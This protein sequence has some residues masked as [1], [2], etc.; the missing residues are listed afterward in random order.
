MIKV[1]TENDS[2]IFDKGAGKAMLKYLLTACE[3][4]IVYDCLEANGFHKLS[5]LIPQAQLEE[6][7]ERVKTLPSTK[8]E[9]KPRKK[10]EDDILLKFDKAFESFNPDGYFQVSESFS[11]NPVILDHPQKIRA[12]ELQ[13][14]LDYLHQQIAEGL[15]G[16]KSN[17]TDIVWVKDL[18]SHGSKL[19]V[20]YLEYNGLKVHFASNTPEYVEKRPNQL[21]DEDLLLG[22]F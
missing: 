18:I 12:D 17:S 16:Y 4:K 2:R 9:K 20:Q 13:T 3:P 5:S 1:T 22:K 11:S 8:K 21:T 7:S 14:K 6:S 10:K 19:G 15:L